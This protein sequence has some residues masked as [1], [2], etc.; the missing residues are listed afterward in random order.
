MRV[1]RVC[2]IDEAGRGPLMGPLVIAG[3]VAPV[4]MLDL[5][6]SMGVKDSKKILSKE[7]RESLHSFIT[8]HGDI[9]WAST[10][11]TSEEI[12]LRR[13]RN[14]T[15]ND[16]ESSAMLALAR[17]LERDSGPFDVRQ[18]REMQ[19]FCCEAVLYSFR[20]CNWIVWRSTLA[21]LSASLMDTLLQWLQSV[22]LTNVWLQ[23]LLL[24]L[25]RRLNAI[26]PLKQSKSS[27]D[28][29]LDLDIH[30]IL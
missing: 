29:R 24:Q 19:F 8:T 12:D 22:E 11:V 14:E 26:V 15:L 18:R 30:P 13:R 27:K 28:A 5:L 1:R 2:G 16:I 23:S 3:V 17:R 4:G 7:K 25:L 20:N 9:G 21:S 6:R 10:H